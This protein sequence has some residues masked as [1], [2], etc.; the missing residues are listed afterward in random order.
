MSPDPQEKTLRPRVDP[1]KDDF[2]RPSLLSRLRVRRRAQ[3]LESRRQVRDRLLARRTH[4]ILAGCGLSQADYS[5]GGGR[6]VRVPEVVSVGAG[7]PMALDIRIL[8]GQVPNDFVAHASAI[9]YGLGMAEVRVVP[10]APSLIRLELLPH[11]E[12]CG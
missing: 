9:A 7:P 11:T 1:M 3:R 10:L 5:I 4:H 6:V 12:S 8:P 2:A